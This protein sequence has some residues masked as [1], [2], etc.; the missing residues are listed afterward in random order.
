MIYKGKIDDLRL[1]NMR[2]AI[3]G[4]M[5]GERKSNLYKKMDCSI[6]NGVNVFEKM[7]AKGYVK[8]SKKKKNSRSFD[9][10]LTEKGKE[11]YKLI[12]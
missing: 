12:V 7:K 2:D 5:N 1:G 4:I 6:T 9:L 11:L 10:E 8:E 3:L